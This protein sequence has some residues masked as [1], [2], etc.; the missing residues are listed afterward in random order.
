MS[1]H[2][3]VEAAAIASSVEAI[4]GHAERVGGAV[5]VRHPALPIPEVNRAIPVEAGVDLAAVAAWFDGA[6]H[7]VVAAPDLPVL[8]ESLPELGYRPARA[9]MAFERGAE[10]TE[11][12]SS[13]L[14]V[15][16]TEDPAAF[17]L[18]L[19]EG[20][21]IPAAANGLFGPLVGAA[22]W[23]CFVAWAGAEPA[24][25]G[26][27][28]VEGPLGWLG[29]A[30]TRPTHRRKGAQLAVLHARIEAARA[31]GVDALYTETGA[32]TADGPGPSYRNILRAG[33]R[34]SYERPNWQSA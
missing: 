20:Y 3:T 5:C 28:Y 34:E 29:M 24:G 13:E 15:E 30:A 21:G 17:D 22:G 25:C 12:V 32:A 7:V 14:R 10:P 26:A 27:L 16:E 2:E 8:A 1:D 18:A 33:F 31:L 11:P 6:P 9:W 23:H 4:G 19:V